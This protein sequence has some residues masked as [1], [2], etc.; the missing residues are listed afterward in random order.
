MF[1]VDNSIEPSIHSDDA[2]DSDLGRNVFAFFFSPEF[3][4][5]L[6]LLLLVETR[7]YCRPCTPLVL[8]STDKVQERASI[9]ATA[10][11]QITSSYSNM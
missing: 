6:L 4:S 9:R 11:V 2:A 3:I 7:S 5:S 10:I 8:E 1:D